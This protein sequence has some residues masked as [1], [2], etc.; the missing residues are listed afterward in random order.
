MN[1][2]GSDR[3]GPDRPKEKPP[4]RAL[5]RTGEVR[6]GW[7]WVGPAK[8]ERTGP[9]PVSQRAAGIGGSGGDGWGLR[10]SPLDAATMAREGSGDSSG[11]RRRLAVVDLGLTGV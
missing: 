11:H 7:A 3:I 10:F 4:E 5:G 8:K 6:P 1:R 2:A 9:R